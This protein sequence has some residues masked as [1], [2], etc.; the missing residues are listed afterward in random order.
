MEK[1]KKIRVFR[2]KVMNI[3][4]KY[5][6]LKK[7][8]RVVVAV[9]GGKDSLALLDVL[10]DLGFNVSAFHIYLGIEKENFSLNSLEIVKS[11]CKERKI[12]LYVFDLRELG[13]TV[14][15]YK[16]TRPKCSFCGLVK[17][18]LT[19]KFAR[20]FGFD[21]LATGHHFDDEV[22]FIFSNLINFNLNYL[23]RQGPLV[24]GKGLPKKIKPFYEVKDCL[25]YTSPS[26][27][28]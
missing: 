22:S 13:K 18:Y 23:V 28:D 1:E 7:E 20:D 26:P 24:G 3:I 25:L 12:P 6:L 14:G 21:A 5:G 2:L 16:G 27:R 9:S 15:N 19:S 10:K 11:F 17:R 8:D 4:Q